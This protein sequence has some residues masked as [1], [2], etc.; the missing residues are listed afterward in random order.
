MNTRLI[1]P[2]AALIIAAG[3]AAPASAASPGQDTKPVKFGKTATYEHA[4]NWFSI[5][6][7][8]AWSAK[9]TSKK[10]EEAIV[11][12]SD[13]TGNAA[14]VVDVFPV[15]KPYDQGDL[16]TL[17]SNFIKSKFKTYKKFSLGKPDG[18]SDTLVALYFKYEQPLGKL[19]IM[20]NGDSFIEIHDGKMIALVTYLI[21][22]EQYKTAE[23]S[24]YAVLNSLKVNP[25]ALESSTPAAGDVET[26][27]AL[28]EYEHPK[29][30]FSLMIPEDWEITDNTKAGTVSVIFA[31]PNGYS[32]VMVEA[33]KNSKGTLKAKDLAKALGDYVDD[34]IGKNV[35]EYEGND[36]KAVNANSASKSFNFVIEAQDGTQTKMTGIVYIDQVGTTLSFLRA[37]LPTD[38]ITANVEKLNEIGDS[39]RVSKTAKF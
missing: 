1:R 28:T 8:T 29:K 7:P 6:V 12:F 3:I 20:M 31:N 30:V 26:I 24:A 35:S 21:P 11:T 2:L 19:N 32:F 38:S 36:V 5:D 4:S 22:A 14:I 39:F 9:D 13:P 17:L 16:S 37:V 18:K 10:G 34:A 33:F 27:G 23:K 15:D 25:D